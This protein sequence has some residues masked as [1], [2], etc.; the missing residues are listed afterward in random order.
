MRYALLLLLLT[1]CSYKFPTPYRGVVPTSKRPGNESTTTALRFNAPGFFPLDTFDGYP[2][3]RVIGY[4]LPEDTVNDAFFKNQMQGQ[5]PFGYS[6]GVLYPGQVWVS[7]D[8]FIDETEIT[9]L[10]WAEYLYYLRR[11][12]S[13]TIFNAMRPDDA[14]LPRPDYFENPFFRFYPIVGITYE[15]AEAYCRWRTTVVNELNRIRMTR[16]GIVPPRKFIL[17]FR[18]PSEAEWETY[19]GCGNDLTKYEQGVIFTESQVKVS[20]KAGNYLKI[21]NNLAE[22]TDKIKA[23]IKDFNKRKQK[24][25][26]F[27]VD[28]KNVPYFLVNQTPYYVFDLPIN[29]YGLYNMIG[30]VAELVKEKGILKGGSYRD[31]ITDISIKKKQEYEGASPTVGFRAVCQIKYI[32]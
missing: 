23:D 15:Q 7:V 3:S 6:K 27:N 9:N 13:Q 32:E 26:M 2:D 25:V 29:N 20:P 12:S 28:R 8:K 21:K 18:L 16:T 17:E 14:K 24:I 19:A 30:N 1:S 11:D 22:S 31:K 5:E 4:K 10:N